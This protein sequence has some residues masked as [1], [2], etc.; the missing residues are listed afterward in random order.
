MVVNNDFSK[1]DLR[2]GDVILR[3]NKRVGIILLELGL[4]IVTDGYDLLSEL[5]DDLTYTVDYPEG[6]I[7]AVRRP[8]T[9]ADCQ[10]TA[11]K[12]CMGTLIYQ[13][14]GI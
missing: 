14:E 3:R 12:N 8:K 1:K 10:F 7:I 9:P 5:N 2:S 13:R 6:D 11:Y 4:I